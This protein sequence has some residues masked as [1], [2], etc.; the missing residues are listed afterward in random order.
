MKNKSF[1]KGLAAG[2]ISIAMIFAGEAVENIYMKPATEAVAPAEV[3]EKADTAEAETQTAEEVKTE[4]PAGAGNTF[5]ASDYGFGGDVT[6]TITVD[7]AGKI[8]AAT[9]EG[10]SETPEI[11]G[12]AV[13]TLAE[14]IVAAQSAEI[15]GVA[16]ASLTSAAAKSAAAKAIEMSKGGAAE[17]EGG[18]LFTPGTYEG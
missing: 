10:P 16:G 18:S 14:Q 7:D 11:G 5:S 13:D 3:E 12:K 2:L 9:V 8:T 4:A 15:D 17:E 1:V 6:V